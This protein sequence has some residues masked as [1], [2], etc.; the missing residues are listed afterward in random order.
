MV[1]RRICPDSRVM[2][3]LA[4]SGEASGGVRRVGGTRVVLLVARVAQRAVQ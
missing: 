3:D 2:T 4:R 1:E